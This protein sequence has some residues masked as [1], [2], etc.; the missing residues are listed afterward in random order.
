MT[1]DQ[2]NN[3]AKLVHGQHA[4]GGLGL[5]KD[6]CHLNH[7]LIVCDKYLT[8]GWNSANKKIVPGY[9]S[10]TI[11]K[12]EFKF[13]KKGNITIIFDVLYLYSNTNSQLFADEIFNSKWLLFLF[14]FFIFYRIFIF[15]KL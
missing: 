5:L 11:S 3:G 6:E 4:R 14:K 8:W 9:L 1:A 15:K 10:S 7:E 13:L 12:N 2:I